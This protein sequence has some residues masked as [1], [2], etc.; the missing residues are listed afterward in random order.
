MVAKDSEVVE[1]SVLTVLYD[2]ENIGTIV[3]RKVLPRKIFGQFQGNATFEQKRNLFDKAAQ[4]SIKIDSEAEGES[5][6]Y[7]AWA[8]WMECVTN[9][10]GR[11]SIDPLPS[12]VEE[13]AVF[14]DFQ[15]EITLPE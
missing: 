8:L 9:I 2:G 11:I 1:G 5:L 14:H 12:R 3:V 6:D 15:V 10:T 4:W 7:S 13:F